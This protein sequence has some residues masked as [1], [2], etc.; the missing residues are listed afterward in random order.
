[1]LGKSGK[2]CRLWARLTVAQAKSWPG[3]SW[4]RLVVVVAQALSPLV[5][6]YLATT[7]KTDAGVRSG[8]KFGPLRLAHPFR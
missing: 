6:A 5:L 8:A 2:I 3:G 1:M 4:L 7:L